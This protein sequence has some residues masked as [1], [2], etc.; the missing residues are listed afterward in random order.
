MRRPLRLA[1]ALGVTVGLLVAFR[2]DSPWI[3]AF[4]VGA[5][6][7]IAMLWAWVNWPRQ[8]ELLRLVLDRPRRTLYWAH[9]GGEPEELP[10]LAVRAIAVEATDHPRYVLLWAIDT[11]GR[12]VQMGQGVRS[13]L[14][15]FAREMAQVMDVPLWYREQASRETSAAR[16]AQP[17]FTR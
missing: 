10:F 13:E 11:S 7:G 3:I 15:A 4:G 5:L 6:A 2:A 14:E 16:P 8:G 17:P 9:R 12:W 1:A